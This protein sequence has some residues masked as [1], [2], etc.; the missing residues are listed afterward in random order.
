MMNEYIQA[1][2]FLYVSPV[3]TI[4]TP[5]H[6]WVNAGMALRV[7]EVNKNCQS[8]RLLLRRGKVRCTAPDLL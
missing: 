3:A 5:P 6:V 7:I 4:A 8:V 1:L 2:S